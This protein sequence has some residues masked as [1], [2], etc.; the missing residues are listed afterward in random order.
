M[1]TQNQRG[2]GGRD[3]IPAPT[4]RPANLTYPDI[5]GE[6][7]ISKG[8]WHALK[9]LYPGAQDESI[10]MVHEYCATRKLDPLK[11]PVH[12]VPMYIKDALSGQGMMRDVIMPGI[13]EM[14]TTASRTGEY[15][16]Q[17]PVKL[18]PV[19]S[20]PVTNARDAPENVNRIE[21]PESATVT[22]YRMVGKTKSAFTH[23]EYFLEAVARDKSGLI[24][25]MWMKRPVGQLSKCAEAGALRKAFPEELGG[26]YAAEELEGQQA[27][28]D[29]D[30]S[31]ALEHGASGIPDPEADAGPEPE[32]GAPEVNAPEPETK[33]VDDDATGLVDPEEAKQAEARIAAREAA[34]K[35]APEVEANKRAQAKAAE[36]AD[37]KQAQK[38]I[39]REMPAMKEGLTVNLPEG[40]ASVLNRQMQIKGIESGQLLA[41]LGESITIANINVALA[42]V[43][44]WG[45]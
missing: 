8:L 35:A 19:I 20:V 26:E 24:N 44:N 37:H 2:R 42:A 38:V 43:K 30:V 16:G 34:K 33:P 21:V 22:V 3:N 5:A 1:G 31:A 45:E 29:I 12:I 15:V 27:A 14:R 23:T 40:A 7:G 6:Y 36:Q 4:V 18:G 9:N 17:E 25:S 39:E 41:K 28:M 13:Q 10:V 32:T 11:K